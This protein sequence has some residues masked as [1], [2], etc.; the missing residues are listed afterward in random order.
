MKPAIAWTLVAA[1]TLA[2]LAALAGQVPAVAS[3]LAVSLVV[4]RRGHGLLLLF[5]VLGAAI[6]GA[7]LGWLQ[8]GGPSIQLG[9]LSFQ[10]DGVIAGVVGSLRLTTVLA[11]NLAIL[12]R[13]RP[14]VWLEG[15]RLP[16]RTNAYLAAVL[17][18]A[19][20]VGRDARRMIEIR[21]FDGRWHEHGRAR[22]A[23]ALLPA[24]M[25]RSWQRARTRREAL[26]LIGIAVPAH[27]APLVAVTALAIAG[28]L[29]LVAIPNVA[30]TYVV[31]FSGGLA[32]GT[33]VGAAAGAWSMLLSD[34]AISGL[35]P[36][37][38]VNVPAMALVGAL[39][40][41]S[42]GFDFSSRFGATVAATIGVVATMLFSTLSDL[43]SWAIVPEFRASPGLL[44]IRLVAGWAFNVV[45]AIAN[46]V[47]FALAAAPVQRA[48]GDQSEQER[49]GTEAGS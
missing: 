4:L 40:G 11:A 14:A 30:L 12:S 19:H 24:L 44:A 15:L 38:F 9:P 35:A 28:R 29:A 26:G 27:F 33:R 42:A 2:T 34:L 6:N 36:T 43:A 16:R 20:D 8:G 3:V 49:H 17:I 25:M 37:S 23:A 1:A 31:V 13:V 7:L 21:R 48:F 32:F 39:G 45:P 47:L 22:A 18:A 46:G 10:R 41:W 5:F